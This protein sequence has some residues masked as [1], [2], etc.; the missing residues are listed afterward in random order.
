MNK[1][2]FLILALLCCVGSSAWGKNYYQQLSYATINSLRN[3]TRNVVLVADNQNYILGFNGTSATSTTKNDANILACAND[4]DYQF[5]MEIDNEGKFTLKAKK[6]SKYLTRS[7]NAVSWSDDAGDFKFSFNKKDTW[8]IRLQN[9]SE[10]LN[11]GTGVSGISYSSGTGPYSYWFVYEIVNGVPENGKYYRIT[12]NRSSNFNVTATADGPT[13]TSTDFTASGI[14]KLNEND[15]KYYIQ[16]LEYLT[17]LTPEGTANSSAALTTKNA[18][19]TEGWTITENNDKQGTYLVTTSTAQINQ[20]NSSP[21]KLCNWGGTTSNPKSNDEGCNIL[22]KEVSIE[23][24]YDIYTVSITGATE[25]SAMYLGHKVNISNGSTYVA[26]KG[27]SIGESLFSAPNGYYIKQIEVLNKQISITLETAKYYYLHCANSGNTQY[28]IRTQLDGKFYDTTDKNQDG[29]GLY[30]LIPAGAANLYY[31]YNVGAQVYLKYTDTNEGN[32]KVQTTANKTDNNTTWWILYENGTSGNV[33]II[34]GSIDVSGYSSSSTFNSFN[35]FG[36]FNKTPKKTL[37]LYRSN[38]GNSSWIFEEVTSDVNNVVNTTKNAYAKYWALDSYKTNMAG[39]IGYL[40]NEAANKLNASEDLATIKINGK[41]L[42]DNDI[43][44]PTTGYYRIQNYDLKWYAYSTNEKFNEN[45]YDYTLLSGKSDKATAINTIWYVTMNGNQLVSAVN[46]NGNKLNKFP[47]G[48]K[49]STKSDISCTLETPIQSD[50]K[51]GTVYMGGAHGTNQAIFTL[52]A[53]NSYNESSNPGIITTWNAKNSNGSRWVFIPVTEPELAKIYKVSID[54][55]GDYNDPVTYNGENYTGDK[56]V[57]NGGLFLFDSKPSSSDFS[58][59]DFSEHRI[60]P[61][62]AVCYVLPDKTI[63]LCYSMPINGELKVIKTVSGNEYAQYN[64][65]AVLSST[66]NTNMLIH[67]NVLTTGSFFI[68]EPGTGDYADYSTIRIAGESNRYVYSLGIAD[69]NSKVATKVVTEGN[70]D[71]TCYWKLT[72]RGDGK[73]N[74]TPKGGDTYGWNKRGS[75]NGYSH[76]GYWNGHNGNTDNQVYIHSIDEEFGIQDLE[77]SK[78]QVGK[79]ADTPANRQIQETVNSETNKLKNHL[80]DIEVNAVLAV[81]QKKSEMTKNEMQNGRYYTFQCAGDK[82]QYL[83]STLSTVSGKE[84]RLGCAASVSNDEIIFY[85]NNSVL[86][87]L[88]SQKFVNGTNQATLNETTGTAYEFKNVSN[89]SNFLICL[90]SSRYLYGN[91][92]GYAD[93]G[94]G[95]DVNYQWIINEVPTQDVTVTAAGWATA[96]IPFKSKIISGNATA[97]YVTVDGTTLT[98]TDADII[99]AEEGVL[100]K[101]TGDEL[102][103]PA[104]ATVTFLQS[105]ATED[106]AT[107]NMMKGSVADG[108]ETFNTA[109]T[110]YYILANDPNDGIGFYWQKGKDGTSVSCAQYKAV[111]AVPGNSSVKGFRLEDDEFTAISDI[112]AATSNRSASFNLAGQVVGNDYKGIVIKNGKKYLNK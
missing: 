71:E 58:Y 107:G 11:T 78:T 70:P 3:T 1:I 102:V 15:G 99:P 28:Y 64:A 56:T 77:I 103:S 42:T 87:G 20:H 27:T 23:D 97:Q 80:S 8:Q 84:S 22:F 45:S 94:S 47:N 79:Y 44:K 101:Y 75:Y 52:D 6:G 31:I 67:K 36:G 35:M 61:K 10:Y 55:N 93:A 12:S 25:I 65:S 81:Y 4:E 95:T 37:G 59:S 69:A 91:S 106:S 26:E 33:D 68:I 38:D 108:G 34:P 21:Y 50:W 18:I 66:D 74:I 73:F 39:S 105:T 53:T 63:K 85:Y 92:I 76:F 7:E 29:G 104:T 5:E 100:I 83:L 13:S 30:T 60:A 41:L 98:K 96:C 40:T 112:E 2:K 19:P 111:L 46:A 24:Y 72:D 32:D 57:K 54:N 62:E 43:V 48:S 14:W 90:T 17:Y 110:K 49:N 89:T 9:G 88:V 109:N 86:F 16:N 51:P 82:E